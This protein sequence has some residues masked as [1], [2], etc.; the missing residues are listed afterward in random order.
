MSFLSSV[1]PLVD[2]GLAFD[3]F[4]DADASSLVELFR[5]V[6]GDEYPSPDVY[7]PDYLAEAN[8]TGAICSYVCRDATGRVVGHLALVRSA[9]FEGTMELAQGLVHPA[10]RGAGV[11]SRMMEVVIGEA[12]R[13]HHCTTLFGT[14][15]CNHVMSQRSLS[16]CGFTPSAFEIDYTP[17]RLFAKE[18]SARGRVATV[19]A[20]RSLAPAPEQVTYLPRAYAAVV[21]DIF[22][23]AN[24]HRR[25]LYSRAD[26]PLGEA[27]AIAVADVPTLDLTKITVARAGRDLARRVQDVERQA[28]NDNRAVVQALVDMSTPGVDTA[29][30]TLRAAGFWFAGVL[31]RYLDADAFLMQKTLATPN[32]EEVKAYAPAAQDLLRVVQADWF[33]ANVSLV[34]T[35]RRRL[36][37]PDPHAGGEGRRSPSRN[38]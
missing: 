15:V 6:W 31:P 16:A 12:G 37:R 38:A 5:T 10:Y 28:R 8:R 13:S 4:G 11:L 3:R 22:R 27:S 25:F 36:A 18:G 7:N 17:A 19:Y 1:A 33:R 29:V 35:A 32:F 30:E 2:H 21:A 14:A 34:V 20:F 9:P 24:T 26:L 23:G